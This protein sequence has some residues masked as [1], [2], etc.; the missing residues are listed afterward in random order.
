MTAV[1]AVLSAKSMVRAHGMFG[2]AVNYF[3]LMAVLVAVFSVFVVMAVRK[4]EHE[5]EK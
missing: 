3:M 1:I 4:M 5:A 2:G